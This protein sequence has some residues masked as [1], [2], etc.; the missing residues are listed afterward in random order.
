MLSRVLI[1]P[2]LLFH[3]DILGR[4]VPGLPNRSGGPIFPF[5]SYPSQLIEPAQAG[6]YHAQ[7]VST[8]DLH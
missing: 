2:I 1:D 3:L 5:Y 7:S 4:V 8:G 6:F